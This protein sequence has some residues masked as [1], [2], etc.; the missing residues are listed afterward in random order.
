[1]TRK[2]ILAIT[3]S[4]I[5]LSSSAGQLYLG[6]GVGPDYAKF[7]ENSQVQQIHNFRLNFN[8]KNDA[9]LSGTGIF[10]TIFAGYGSRFKLPLTTY[11]NESAYLAIELNANISSL[12]HKTKNDEFVHASF[13]STKFRMQHEYG[14]SI[15]PGF[16]YQDATLFYGRLGYARNNLKVVTNDISLQN[17]NHQ[18][19]GFRW[20]LGIRQSLSARV[21]MRVE[22]NHV[23]YRSVRMST[24]DVLS[25]TSKI[26]HITPQTNEVEFGLMYLF[27]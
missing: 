11:P 26:T 8:V 21:A 4:I 1:M 19:N 17:I 6:L 2:V 3:T 16:F 12:Q 14:A 27:G 13:T 15:V 9:Q 22:Y 23:G 25:N 18:V 7:Q 20:G 10:G 24:L 5:S